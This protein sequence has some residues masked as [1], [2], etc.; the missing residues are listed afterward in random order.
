MPGFQSQQAVYNLKKNA[1]EKGMRLNNLLRE[2]KSTILKKWWE[3]ILQ[4]YP[5]EAET[6]LKQDDPF[7]NPVGY[8]IKHA[9]DDIFR[10][11][12]E[13]MDT[14]DVENA[15][16]FL[17]NL[18]R[19]RAVQDFTPA[20]AISFIFLLKRVIRE[21]LK[22]EI[23]SDMSYEELLAFESKIDEIALSCF[24]LYMKCR[25][26]IY[27]L[28]ADELRRMTFGLLRG[29]NQTYRDL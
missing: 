14:M 8:N 29:A 16:S 17:T 22:S 27:E 5:S 21:E 18:I 25:E 1:L 6:Q 13:R 10:G 19:I 3:L 20:R 24:D 15:S 9:I 7:T 11:L 4:T 23:P 2:K 26:K 12:I 28:K